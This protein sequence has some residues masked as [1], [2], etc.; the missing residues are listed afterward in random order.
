MEISAALISIPDRRNG[1]IRRIKA[2]YP[3]H[4]FI[5]AGFMFEAMITTYTALKKT[6]I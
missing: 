4:M 1:C 6:L 2:L 3:V 5:M